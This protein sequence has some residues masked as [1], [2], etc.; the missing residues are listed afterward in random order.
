MPDAVPQHIAFIMDGNRRWARQ[1]GLPTLKGHEQGF[2]TAQNL[3]NW[4]D[5]AGVKYCTLYTFSTENWNRDL[6]EVKYL[7]KLLVKVFT[8]HLK[9]FQEKNVRLI[10][11]GRVD[12]FSHEVKTAIKKAVRL[13]R[14]NTRAVVNLALNYGGR[15]ELIDAV[16]QLLADNIP[17]DKIDEK[18]LAKHLY[19]NGQ[20]PDPELIIRTG[21]EK[22]LSNFLPWQSVYSELYFTNTLWPDFSQKDL[23][24]ALREFAA[25]ERRF[26]K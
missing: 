18:M 26:G 24:A 7:M 16:K 5:E 12:E 22:R 4:L 15:A 10:V 11:S 3:L 2:E 1:R 25:R 19:S 6:S 14:N 13:T 21:G 23:Q 20:L 9:E 17:P 8:Q